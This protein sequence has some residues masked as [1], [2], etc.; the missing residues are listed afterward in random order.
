MSKISN[1]IIKDHFTKNKDQESITS[2]TMGMANAVKNLS[3][4]LLIQKLLPLQF[5]AMQQG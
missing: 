5:Q 1:V 2:E 4:S 3:M